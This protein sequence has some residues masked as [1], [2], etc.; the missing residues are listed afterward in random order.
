MLRLYLRK[1]LPK[2]GVSA[3]P[4]MSFVSI[5]RQFAPKNRKCLAYALVYDQTFIV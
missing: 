3:R 1:A 5:S 2:S 4:K